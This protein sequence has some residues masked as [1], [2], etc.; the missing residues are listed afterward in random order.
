MY[1]V[2]LASFL[3][4]LLFLEHC[5]LTKSDFNWTVYTTSDFNRNLVLF[6]MSGPNPT[7]KPLKVILTQLFACSLRV[8]RI[9]DILYNSLVYINLETTSMYTISFY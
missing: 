3:P 6:Y 5:S 8:Y 2:Y 9:L 7:H 4:R 1:F